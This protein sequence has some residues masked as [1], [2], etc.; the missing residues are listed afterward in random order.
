MSDD[1]TMTEWKKSDGTIIKLND[2]PATVKKA[3]ELGWER[4]K[5]PKPKAD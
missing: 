3:E 2:A 1:V 4:K 5:G